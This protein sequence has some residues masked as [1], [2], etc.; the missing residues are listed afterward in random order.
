MPA[1]SPF[2][3]RL[4]SGTSF[5]PSTEPETR[6]SMTAKQDPFPFM[7]DQSATVEL[8]D[9][10][11]REV[12][13]QYRR[14]RKARFKV[15]TP[16]DVAGFLRQQSIDNS[17]EQF[18]ALY[19]DG[20]HHV[21]GYSLVAIGGANSCGVH[22]REVFQRA[23]LSGAVALVVAHNH[24]S[25]SLEP[26]QADWSMTGRLQQAGTVLSIPLLDHVIFTDRG[27]FSMRDSGKWQHG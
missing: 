27:H 25:G 1:S 7:N 16:E 23:V 11:I 20:S 21:A 17:R 14:S 4:P 10:F 8:E 15:S 12:R 3:G 5:L 22:P 13:V 19:L 26:S 2:I 9:H 18:F 24:P 6:R